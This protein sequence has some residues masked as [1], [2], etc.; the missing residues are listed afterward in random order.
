MKFLESMPKKF[1]DIS[2]RLIV[3][4]GL[5]TIVLEMVSFIHFDITGQ[6]KISEDYEIGMQYVKCIVISLVG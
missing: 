3:E 1:T 5:I 6:E 2:K 4:K